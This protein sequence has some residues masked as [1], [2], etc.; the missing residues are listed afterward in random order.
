MSDESKAI[1]IVAPEVKPPPTYREIKMNDFIALKRDGSDNAPDN[2]NPFWIIASD[3]MFLHQRNILGRGI[4]KQKTLP[5]FLPKLDSGG[6]FWWEAPTI[7]ASIC[8]QIVDFFV[9]VFERHKTEAEVILLMNYETNEWGV[10]VPVQKVSHSAVDS[11]FDPTDVPAKHLIVGTMHSHCDFSPFHSGTDVGDAQ[12]MNGAHFTVGYVD[13][14]PEFVAMVM[15]NGTQF[16]YEPSELADFSDLKAGA[17]PEE[18]FEK[19]I[20]TASLASNHLPKDYKDVFDKF[21]KK[22]I[23]PTTTH[24]YT[25]TIGYGSWNWDNDDEDWWVDYRR[26]HNTNRWEAS[27]SP[28]IKDVTPRWTDYLTDQAYDAILKADTFTEEDW[29]KVYK[30][31]SLGEDVNYWRSLFLT[32]LSE[33]ASVLHHLGMTVDY[34]AKMKPLTK[35][36]LDKMNLE[37]ALLPEDTQKKTLAENLEDEGFTILEVKEDGQ[38]VI[39]VSKVH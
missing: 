37:E 12:D 17:A 8:A 13:K 34:S 18:W 7:P 3:G 38:V 9:K 11:A 16:N 25:P 30:N 29:L 5:K 2:K 1:V 6:N 15:Q 26:Q 10:F 39:D 24:T 4:T 28:I 21:G 27:K 31:P 20:P 35:E 32:K 36:D 33:V 19:I 22:A 23:P 14:T